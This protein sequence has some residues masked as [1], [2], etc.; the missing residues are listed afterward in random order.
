[1]SEGIE[2][3]KPSKKN[4]LTYGAIAAGGVV[5]LLVMMNRGGASEVSGGGGGVNTDQP[6][7]I[8]AGNGGTSGPDAT[9][10]AALSDLASNQQTL[11]DGV[12]SGFNSMWNLIQSQAA[13]PG[14]IPTGPTSTVP[15][16]PAAAVTTLPKIY[17]VFG[18]PDDIDSARQRWAHETNVRYTDTSNMSYAETRAALAAAGSYGLIAG[19]YASG[20][21]VD[22]AE[23]FGLG[24]TRIYGNDRQG[25]LTALQNFNFN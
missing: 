20:G 19:G 17:T 25:T 12:T 5:I 15:E 7:I 11:S 16:A 18:A 3:V 9:T 24:I 8:P 22:E 13:A 2:G 10:I 1:M 23:A 6:I 21:G 4:L 14:P